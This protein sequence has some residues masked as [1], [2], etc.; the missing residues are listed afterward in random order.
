MLIGPVILH[1]HMTRQTCLDFLRNGLPEQLE[2]V[3]L[4]ARIGMYFQ[5]EGAPSHYTQRVLQ[6]LNETFPSQWI[7]RSSTINWPPR[8][9]DLTPLD[10]CLWSWIKGA[11]Y[12]RKDDTRDELLDLIMGLIARTK[13]RQDALRRTTRLVLT[14]VAKRTETDGGIFENVLYYV[15]C[16]N[17]VT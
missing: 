11:V 2:D 15:N 5:Y 12:R 3:P 16:T 4:A 13:E 7:G 10:F 8:S 9:P 14:R 6:H 17:F 1:D